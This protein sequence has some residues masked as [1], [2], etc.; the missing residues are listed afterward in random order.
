[1]S[2]RC[3]RTSERR[4]EWRSTPRVHFICFLSNVRHNR[5]RPCSLFFT[6]SHLLSSEVLLFLAFGRCQFA[7]VGVLK[8]HEAKSFANLLL[9]VDGKCDLLDLAIFLKVFPNRN[10]I[11]QRVARQVG[12]WETQIIN[13]GFDYF[14]GNLTII[15][16]MLKARQVPTNLISASGK[17]GLTPPTKIF[18]TLSYKLKT[19][20]K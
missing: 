18:F 17:S 9:F 10:K 5:Q 1:M 19:I 4:S 14:H 15:S 7:G 13:S 20:Q 3:E 12:S 16:T 6:E 8:C 2:D 11:S